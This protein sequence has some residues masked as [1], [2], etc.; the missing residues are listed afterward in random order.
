MGCHSSPLL[1]GHTYYP[2]FLHNPI[3]GIQPVHCQ[4]RRP[5]QVTKNLNQKFYI[6]TDVFQLNMIRKS[7]DVGEQEVKSTRVISHDGYNIGTWGVH[8]VIVLII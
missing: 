6:L 3:T 5:K 4:G 2:K 1:P 8:N 7:V